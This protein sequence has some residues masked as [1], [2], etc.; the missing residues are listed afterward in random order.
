MTLFIFI[1]WMLLGGYM[2]VENSD[3]IAS[4]DDKKTKAIGMAVITVA[5]PF[6]MLNN[7]FDY[8]L[9]EI[10]GDVWEDDDDETGTC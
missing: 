3:L 5:A 1:I 10:F 2:L 7:L 8:M 6:C 9:G 4:V